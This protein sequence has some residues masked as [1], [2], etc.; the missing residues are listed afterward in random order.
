MR[1][2]IIGFL[3]CLLLTTTFL[4]VSS[5]TIS[6]LNQPNSP[7]SQP[8]PGDLKRP[9][10]DFVTIDTSQK[11]LA[12]PRVFPQN[13]DDTI[14]TMIESIDESL[15]LGYLENLTDF[16]PRVTGTTACEEAGDYIYDEFQDMGLEVRYHEW[17]YSGYSDRNIEATLEGTNE[18][19]DEI[20]IIC[21]HYD[22]VPTS[23]GADDDGSGTV[24]VMAAAYIMSQYTFN[25]TIR[26]VAFSGEEQ[27]LLG[28]HEYARDAYSNGD[29]IVGV[30]NADM[31]GFAITTEDGENIKVYYNDASVWLLEFTDDISEEYY[32]YINLNIIP[33]GF[34]WGSDHYS[35]WEN[36]YDAIFYHEYEFNHYYHSSQDIIE[37]MNLT[38]DVKCSKLILATLAELA[39]PGFLSNP[40]EA[41]TISGPTSGI[42]GIE[43]EFT[44][45]SEDPD[46]DDVYYYVDW[47][48]ETYN[49]WIGPYQSGEEIT[50]THTFTEKGAFSIT[51]KAK[52]AYGVQSD[53]SDPYNVDILT[54]VIEIDV[55]KGGLFKVKTILKNMADVDINNVDWSI[56]LEGGLIFIGDISSGTITS[57]PPGGEVPI[58]SGIILGFGET[59][60]RVTVEIPECTDTREQDAR[61][62]LFYIKVNPGGSI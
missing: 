37:N 38:Y 41:P 34:S 61:V 50:L 21:A 18:T 60:V 25:H 24:A 5:Q 20:Y 8:I 43:Y 49:D 16:R 7:I 22:S 12:P 47:G 62:F 17:S 53:I 23:P 55:I 26:F 13:I 3:I 4:P 2:K 19:S 54:S 27:G 46:G 56:V 59:K 40:P 9:L 6:H 51:A 39:K 11:K 14:I 35:F 15:I 44:F 48:D 32:D 31:I 57:I 36:E 1:K 29:N 10:S 58:S 33:S 28:S 52:D 30:L 45:V 42:A